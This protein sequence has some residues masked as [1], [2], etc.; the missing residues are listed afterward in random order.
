MKVFLQSLGCSKN[1]VDSEMILGVCKNLGFKI[2]DTPNNCD[3]LIVNTCAFIE[4]AREEAINTILEIADYKTKKTKM[5]VSG[6]LSTRYKKELPAELPEVDLFISIIDYSHLAELISGLFD[7]KSKDNPQL[8]FCDRVYLSNADYMKY[9]RISDGCLNRCAFC[10]IPQIRGLLKS[11]TILDI[12]KEVEMHVKNNC[13]EINIISQDTTNYGYDLE[14][15][16]MLVDL[17]KELVSIPGDFKIRLFYLYPEIVTDELIDFIKNN[18]KMIPY[19]DIPIQHSENKILKKMLRRSTKEEMK[20]LFKKI[21]HEIPN[22]ILRTTVMVGFPYEEEEDVHNLCEFIKEIK[23]DRLGCFTFSLEE[24]TPATHYPQEISE[25]EKMRRYNIVMDTQYPISLSLNESHLGEITNVIIE[26][27]DEE[28]L[29]YTGRNYAFA[30]DDIDGI[31]YIAAHSEKQIGDIV[32]V[33][34]VDADAYSLTA[35]EIDEEN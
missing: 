20:E 23:F 32:K 2:S 25:E 6:C 27:Y 24:N 17:L 7:I 9:V 22:A 15:R 19:F 29:M 16:L 14:K 34:I 18:E 35:E 33:K 30:P 5:I 10:A 11:R 4:K 8:D 13:K 3:L 1:Q 21:R 26:G 12:K 31:I 28:N